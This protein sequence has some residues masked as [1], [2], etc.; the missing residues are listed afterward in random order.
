M[1]SGPSIY[2]SKQLVILTFLQMIRVSRSNI[3]SE[4]GY[5]FDPPVRRVAYVLCYTLCSPG[6]P[7][8]AG[9]PC[10]PDDYIFAYYIRLFISDFRLLEASAPV[11][12]AVIGPGY[13]V[14]HAALPRTIVSFPMYCSASNYE[15]RDL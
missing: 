7:C 10:L 4:I 8:S 6:G 11:P 1:C 5:S 9:W 2:D 12:R 15:Y 14:L 13:L 3:T